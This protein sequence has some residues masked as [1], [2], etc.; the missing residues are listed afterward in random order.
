[1][2][3]AS[4]SEFGAEKVRLV[5]KGKKKKTKVLHQDIEEEVY[6]LLLRRPCTFEQTWQA[7]NMDPNSLRPVI[8]KLLDDGK[9]E[10]IVSETGEYYRAK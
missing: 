7:L 3:T 5:L 1:M 9:I 6:A 10:E 4:F 2:L 8:E